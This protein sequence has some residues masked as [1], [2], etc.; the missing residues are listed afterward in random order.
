MLLSYVQTENTSLNSSHIMTQ[1]ILE[2]VAL[3]PLQ[4]H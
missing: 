4:E 2:M 3:A 1:L